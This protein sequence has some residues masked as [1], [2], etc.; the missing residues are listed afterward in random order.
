MQGENT[1]NNKENKLHFKKATKKRA[2]QRVY[3]QRASVYLQHQEMKW[4]K[5]NEEIKTFAVDVPHTGILSSSLPIASMKCHVFTNTL[6]QVIY[7]SD[8]QR[9]ANSYHNMALV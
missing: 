8:L 5:W 7:V 2:D 4:R 3:N 9:L 6:E 1:I